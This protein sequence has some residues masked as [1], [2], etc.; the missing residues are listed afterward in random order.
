[1]KKVDDY[2]YWLRLELL[3]VH[4]DFNS[5]S[6]ADSLIQNLQSEYPLDPLVL[7]YSA[8]VDRH[9]LRYRQAIDKL[10]RYL[11]LR[12]RDEQALEQLAR[13]YLHQQD[14]HQLATTLNHFPEKAHHSRV[15]LI[16]R[17][18]L[19]ILRG[20]LNQ[21]RNYLKTALLNYPG[22][23]E[24]ERLWQLLFLEPPPRTTEQVLSELERQAYRD[25]IDQHLQFI[26][27]KEK[28]HYQGHRLLCGAEGFAYIH[29]NDP[30]TFTLIQEPYE[31]TRLTPTE[32]RQRLKTIQDYFFQLNHLTYRDVFLTMEYENSGYFLL[33]LY[34]TD[35]TY[36]RYREGQFQ[37]DSLP[38]FLKFRRI[39]RQSAAPM[40]LDLLL[41][42]DKGFIWISV[43]VATEKIH[44]LPGDWQ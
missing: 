19:E 32:A 11:R 29:Q 31:K 23:L 36:E 12:P 27:V 18:Q 41:R 25:W 35:S 3:E 30:H 16:L 39:P 40:E 5:L 37:G 15:Y 13:I 44:I 6:G 43:R 24:A 10:H 21:A 8:L 1:M 42:Q 28:Y 4:L 14:V 9:A 7:Y 33:H 17:A 34:E 20:D 22:N 26:G 38:V 2:L